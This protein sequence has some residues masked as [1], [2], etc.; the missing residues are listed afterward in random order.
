MSDNKSKETISTAQS[1]SLAQDSSEIFDTYKQGI[2]K[3]TEAISKFQPKYVQMISKLQEEYIQL[4]KQFIDKVFAAERNWAGGNVTATSTTFPSPIYA[5]YAE[6]FR[7]ESNE[8]QFEQ[9][10]ASGA[11]TNRLSG[12]SEASSNY[13]SIP[14]P[15]IMSGDG[16]RYPNQ[17]TIHIDPVLII[18]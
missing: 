15:Q 5:P 11:V 10:L 14:V 17:V 8:T 2:L 3:L 16:W 4:T 12:E 1:N 9:N 6:Q 13:P 7:R 18:Q